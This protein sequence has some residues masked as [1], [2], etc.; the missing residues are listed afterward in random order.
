MLSNQSSEDL[1]NADVLMSPAL[2]CDDYTTLAK[3]L[4]LPKALEDMVN[5]LLGKLN[6]ANMVED[7]VPD[8]TGT[9][10]QDID[11]RLDKLQSLEKI[12]NLVQ[13]SMTENSRR[14]ANYNNLRTRKRRY[15]VG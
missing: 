1:E 6:M 12:F 4:G 7:M 13:S 5:R 11:Q 3:G 2:M 15:D 8:K 10:E 9:N 14:H